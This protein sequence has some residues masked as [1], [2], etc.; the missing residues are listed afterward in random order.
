MSKEVTRNELRELIDYD[1]SGDLSSN[2]INQEKSP[3]FK[4]L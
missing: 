1:S 2:S 3:D 4:N